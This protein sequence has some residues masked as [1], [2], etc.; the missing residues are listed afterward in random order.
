M[1]EGNVFEQN[2]QLGNNDEKYTL[3]HTHA[4]AFL[5]L[6]DE[7]IDICNFQAKMISYM[8]LIQ[9]DLFKKRREWEFPGL[10]TENLTNALYLIFLAIIGHNTQPYFS[11][12][13]GQTSLQTIIL[14]HAIWNTIMEWL[15]PTKTFLL[16]HFMENWIYIFEIPLSTILGIYFTFTLYLFI[17]FRFFSICSRTHIFSCISSTIYIVCITMCR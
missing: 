17:P 8:L 13:F 12:G 9:H 6:N 16:I 11:F 4:A 1:Q 15:R 2:M 7:H 14:Y 10:I 3:I 5:C